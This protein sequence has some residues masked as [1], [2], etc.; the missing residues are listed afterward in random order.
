MLQ[1]VSS[2]TVIMLTPDFITANY[3]LLCVI[4]VD[5][6]NILKNIK[7][8]RQTSTQ[9]K[10]YRLEYDLVLIFGC[11]EFKAQIAWKEKGAEK[12]YSYQTPSYLLRELIMTA[13]SW[14]AFN[15]SPA[16]IL[17]NYHTAV[18]PDTSS[19]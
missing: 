11:T 12:R 14:I 13:L 5:V 6:T 4:K 18:T 2:S 8:T 19:S 15:R 3:S 9:G 16:K 1:F 10:F 17:Y 7:A